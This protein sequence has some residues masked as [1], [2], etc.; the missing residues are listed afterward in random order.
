[1]I[2]ATPGRLIDIVASGPLSLTAIT[3]LVVD[4]AD[5]MLQLGQF[6]LDTARML[7]GEHQQHGPWYGCF[8]CS[9]TC[10]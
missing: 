7:H 1:M 2:V 6:V 9:C 4:E 10:V 3:Y 5:R 8:D